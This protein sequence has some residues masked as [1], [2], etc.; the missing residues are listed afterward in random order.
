[1]HP[2]VDHLDTV[3][4][5]AT[6]RTANRLQWKT[7]PLLMTGHQMQTALDQ[8]SGQLLIAVSPAHMPVRPRDDVGDTHRSHRVEQSEVFHAHRQVQVEQSQTLRSPGQQL[9]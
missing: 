5:V 7:Q 1:M 2:R 3:G 9:V 6:L 8:V 4:R